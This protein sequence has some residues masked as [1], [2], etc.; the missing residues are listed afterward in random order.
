LPVPRR[1]DSD[2]EIASDDSDPDFERFL[3][4][5]NRRKDIDD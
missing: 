3:V 4:G 1:Q 5:A 2:D